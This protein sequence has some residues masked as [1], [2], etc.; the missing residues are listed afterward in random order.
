LGNGYRVSPQR[1]TL[2]S[3]I[4]YRHDP[5]IPLV[6]LGAFVLL[7]GLCISFYLLPA[8]LYVRI[9]GSGRAWSVGIAATTVKGY[10]LF[11]DQF[12]AIVAEFEQS[13]QHALKAHA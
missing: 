11:E 10:D 2:F 6:G 13:E 5:G 1:W 4:Q 8:R 12:R 7:A 3:G 9:E